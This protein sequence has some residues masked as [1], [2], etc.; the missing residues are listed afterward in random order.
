MSRDMVNGKE[1]LREPYILNPRIDWEVA[2]KYTGNHTV[3][4][5]QS[6]H[7]LVMDGAG[8]N[9]TFTLPSLGAANDGFEIT[10]VNM[11]TGRL[12]IDA[13]GST[14]I[15][16]ATYTTI[17]SDDSNV[18]QITLRYVYEADRLYIKSAHGS[19]TTSA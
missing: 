14:T 10:C 11:D 9:Y 5:A 17:Y 6:G 18:A 12:S 4:L 16:H 13:V 7:T 8:S 3:T 2:T 15:A 1:V 19:W